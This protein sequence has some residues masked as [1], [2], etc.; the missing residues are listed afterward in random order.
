MKDISKATLAFRL[1]ATILVLK[2]TQNR[3][4]FDHPDYINEWNVEQNLLLSRSKPPQSQK[5][6]VTKNFECCSR[7]VRVAC[8]R[9]ICRI[10]SQNGARP[11]LLPETMICVRIN[12]NKSFD[13]KNAFPSPSCRVLLLGLSKYLTE[14]TSNFTQAPSSIPIPLSLP[15]PIFHAQEQRRYGNTSDSSIRRS[16]SSS[17]KSVTW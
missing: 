13:L 6:I 16:S 3:V 7:G 2:L 9:T 5:I 1:L 12:L 10:D 17:L 4:S 15:W 8:V 14:Q 11:H